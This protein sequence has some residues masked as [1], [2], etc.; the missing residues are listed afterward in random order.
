MNL[1]SKLFGVL[2]TGLVFASGCDKSESGKTNIICL[3]SDLQNDVLAF[4]P[5]SGGSL[6][7]FSGNNHHLINN[8]TAIPGTDRAGNPNCAFLFTHNNNLD[9]FLLQ[10]NPLFLNGLSEF[11]VS[12]WYMPLDTSRLG[13]QYEA[14]ICRDLGMHCPDKMGQ[15]SLGLYDCRRAVFGRSNNAWEATNFTAGMTCEDVVLANTN[16]W[17]HAV[18]TFRLS[19]MKMALYENGVL[20][21]VATGNADCG[22]GTTPV[23]DIGDLFLGKNYNGLLDDVIIYSRALTASEI[24]QLY[25][26][27]PCCQ[28]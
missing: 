23:L 1:K 24:A 9:E 15:W 6:N 14:L 4:Y 17:Q 28:N 25:Q 27:A 10:S 18:I 16:N 26:V 5:F 21:K 22:V 19:G 7:D 11:S 3:P 13:S 12:L 2:L 20:Q 8:T